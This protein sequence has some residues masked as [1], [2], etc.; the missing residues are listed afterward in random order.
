M[1]TRR[2]RFATIPLTLAVLLAV[3]APVAAALPPGGTF[4]D[5]NGST[6]EP[7]IEAVAAEGI[8]SG[9]GGGRFCPEDF[10]T[11]GQM[12]AFLARGLDLV[13]TSGVHFSDVPTSHPFWLS[14]NRLATAGIST[15]CGGGRFCPNELRQP[16]PDGRVP[17][18]CARPGLHERRELQ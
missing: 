11:R 5:D 6:F 17:R 7:A 16:R 9:C 13:S 3:V 1:P 4:I 14:I 18:A 2:G 12:A 8:A 10:V 15:G